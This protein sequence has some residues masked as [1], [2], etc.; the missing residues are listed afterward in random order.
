MKFAL[1]LALAILNTISGSKISNKNILLPLADIEVEYEITA[2]GGCFD[3][4]AS[5]SAIAITVQ[6]QQGCSKSIG[7]VRVV[8]KMPSQTFI[9]VKPK[10]SDASQFIVEVVVQ[11]ISSLS[12]IT[13]Q[14]QLDL[15]TQ[16]E[17]HV[18]AYDDKGN[19]FTTLE[20]LKFEW[21][22][23]QLE[24]VKFTESGLKVS[25]KRARLEFN[26]DII[27]VKGKKEGK[28]T[29]FTRVVEKKYYENKIE[30][31]VDLVVIQK[32]QFYP[33]YPVFYLP[34]HSV[35]QF[36]LLRADGKTKISIPSAAHVW[37]TTSKL[38]K[39]EQNGALTTQTVEKNLNLTVVNSNYNQIKAIYHV[40]IP[41]YIDIDIWEDGKEKREGKVTH[42]IVGKLY[43][44]QAYLKDELHQRIYST[45]AFSYESKD[46]E[47]IEQTVISKVERQNVKLTF[48]R[49]TLESSVTIHFVQPIQIS[50]IFKTYI[51]LPIHEQY[52]LVVTGGS[53]NYKY[54]SR[55]Q[56]P[57]IFEIKSPHTLVASELG[58]NILIIY[59]EFNV[60]NSLEVTVYVT[61]VSQ[62]LPFERR[63][64]L[65]VNESDDTF[66][67]AIGDPK[68]GN[69]TQCR[70]VKFTIDNFDIFTTSQIA[71]DLSNYLVC[72][73]L[74][75]QSA[76]P[77]QYNLQINTQKISVTQQVRV[78]DYLHFE[79]PVY[80]VTPHSTI[81]T[82]VL[83]GP[84]TWDQTP[85]NE[86][87]SE[88]I[89][90]IDMEKYHFNCFQSKA[91]FRITRINKQS[92]L[93]PN[94]K[95]VSNTLPI[96]CLLP[97]AFKIYNEKNQEV[98]WLFKEETV[99]ISV[100][101]VY[102]TFLFYNSS[103][104]HLDYSTRGLKYQ[105][106]Y[107]SYDIQSGISDCK[108]IVASNSY[109]NHKDTFITIK[110]ELD[111][112]IHHTLKLIPSGE[113]YDSD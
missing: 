75:M 87:L 80:Y 95:L 8:T 67:Q 52:N 84:T 62:I 71:G 73:G 63:K 70:A 30:T 43:R 29:V 45:D 5:N 77:G 78:Y 44:F 112:I 34:T 7:K 79:K 103:S 82:K 106:R 40:V 92:D 32:F 50:T 91:E 104:L 100:V 76:T 46:I 99:Q 59:D 56:S 27:V 54:Q 86:K 53:G 2:E 1:I 39:I 111:L 113:Q 24:M 72:N 28:E 14:K 31:N 3:W 58:E 55:Y 57:T 98:N 26:S 22:T 109:N 74:K 23:G 61:D 65:I 37:S 68:V 96:Q 107:L 93:L 18:Q 19:T 47:L 89:L 88:G 51:H 36:H 110:S 15:D 105:N 25:E 94:P 85:Y 13:K 108:F 20:G 81:T 60:Y 69:Y 49:G 83:G 48:Q 35:I 66:Y 90:K 38:S 17:L 10:S 21:K 6:D 42:L 12:I 4:S 11:A 97:E 101:A 102:K 16:E 64:E 41:K 33:D 9:Y